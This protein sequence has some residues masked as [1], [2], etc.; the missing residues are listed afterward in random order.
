MITDKRITHMAVEYA[1]R[2]KNNMPITPVL[3]QQLIRII[4]S[5]QRV[6]CE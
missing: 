3:K 1:K 5:K 2:S 6:L 4:T